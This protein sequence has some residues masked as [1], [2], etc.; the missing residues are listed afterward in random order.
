MTRNYNEVALFEHSFWLQILGDHARFINDSLAESEKE[1][2]EKA[3]Y[4][5]HVFD[6]LLQNV[7]IMNPMEL[8]NL[9]EREVLLL[10][11]FKLNLI[12]R[13]LVGK[14]FV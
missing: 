5:I 2:I 1:L 14:K 3:Q 8:S 12:E 11:T 4:F 6:E 7:T 13:H 9:A 10:K